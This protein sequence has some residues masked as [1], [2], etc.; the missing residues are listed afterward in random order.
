[1]LNGLNHEYL[2]KI[3]HDFDEINLV[4]CFSNLEDSYLMNKIRWRNTYV[5]EPM[6]MPES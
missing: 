5:D 1:M 6:Q 2:A 4:S 3:Y